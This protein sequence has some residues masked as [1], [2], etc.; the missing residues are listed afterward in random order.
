MRR[1]SP[2]KSIYAAIL[3]G[4]AGTR[5]WPLS[6]ARTPKQ[7]LK[8][9]GPESLLSST[10]GRLSPL[11]PPERVFIVTSSA[12]AGVIRRHLSGARRPFKGGYIIEP[13]GR[14]TAPAIALAAFA[15]YRKDPDAVMAVL[16][17]DHVIG[18]PQKFRR[19]L[20]AAI[21][22]AA[23]GHLVTFGIPPTRPE[24][25]YGYIKAVGRAAK[26]ID[27][28]RVL[29]VERFV[30]KPNIRRARGYLKTGGY[31]W[32][33]GINVWK[34]SRILEEIK[35]HLP[36]VYKAVGGRQGRGR[37]A[38]TFA[39]MDPVSIDRG[40]LEK[41]D[42]VV[43]IPAS[44]GWS[45]MGSWT[46]LS[47]RIRPDGRGNIIKGNSIDIDSVGSTIIATEG[48]RV[49][50]TIGL[51]DMIVVDTPDATLI[52]PKGK[53]DRVAAI[54]AALKLKGFNR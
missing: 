5:L 44:F 23:R 22:A 54:V 31:L 46:A 10:I 8:I 1:V 49:L 38:K 48:A 4:G 39:S 21:K 47:D 24:P 20:S 33:S 41:A 43:V 3:A 7:L 51:K 36:A 52:C 16:P 29:K 26:R 35:T 2:G 17:S 45:D 30:E 9:V 40:V 50:A 28:Y 15:L 6:S 37:A 25:A 18:D 13:M 27:G 42:D 12:Q 19:A 32:N 14:N 11:I 34:V 53:A